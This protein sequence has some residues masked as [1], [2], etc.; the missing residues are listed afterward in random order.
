MVHSTRVPYLALVSLLVAARVSGQDQPQPMLVWKVP[1]I[2]FVEYQAKTSK[3]S[4]DKLVKTI[5]GKPDSVAGFYSHEVIDGKSVRFSHSTLL[6]VVAEVALSLSGDEPKSGRKKKTMLYFDAT[7]RFGRL[8]AR[9]VVTT[10]EVDDPSRISQT[11]K[12]KLTKV[13]S[14]HLDDGRKLGQGALRGSHD[15]ANGVLTFARV[16]DAIAGRVTSFTARLTGSIFPERGG[17]RRAK[18]L[19]IEVAWMFKAI[20][21]PDTASFRKRVNAAIDRGQKYLADHVKEWLGK[22]KVFHRKTDDL[23]RHWGTGY[24]SLVLLTLCKRTVER[25]TKEVHAMLD[26]LRRRVDPEDTYS[27]A[28]SIM[29]IESYY[30]PPTEAEQI[31]A[32]VLDRPSERKLP[33]EDFTLVQGWARRLLA[34]RDGSTNTY[35]WRFR[36][37]GENSFDNSC[38]QFAALGLASAE[39]CGVQLPG[40]LWPGLAQHY[41]GEQSYDEGKPFPLALASYADVRAEKRAKGGGTTTRASV[42]RQNAVARGF[43]YQKKLSPH[44]SMTCAGLVGLTIVRARLAAAGRAGT[45]SGRALETAARN[46]FAWVYKNYDMRNNPRFERKWYFYYL[47]ALERACELAGVA[48]INERDWYFDG[49]MQLLGMQTKK[50]DWPEDETHEGLADTCFAILFLKKAVAPVVTR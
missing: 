50:G 36:Y 45:K 39:R 21:Q 24:L 9:G 5:H 47:Y 49:A 33:A 29:A 13:K 18:K 41:L 23:R 46:G 38:T 2:G 20:E 31:R 30:E 16:V 22:D 28:T 6:D 35:R 1:G 3:I 44:G 11:G 8:R 7:H 12:L 26:E 48:R 14:A 42:R 43:G 15:L 17:K 4:P 27:L 25:D 32:G 34:N 40:T 37:H 19:T 10:G